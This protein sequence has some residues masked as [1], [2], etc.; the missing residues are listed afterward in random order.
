MPA[1]T[2]LGISYPLYGDAISTTQAQFQDMAEDMD[3][4]AQQLVNRLDAAAMRPAC[5]L[6]NFTNQSIVTNT[7][8]TAVWDFADFNNAGMGNIA[9]SNTRIQLIEQGIYIVGAALIFA[10]AAGTYSVHATL[11]ATAGFGGGTTSLRGVSST[12]DTAPDRTHINPV[13]MFYADGVTTADVTVV[14]RHNAAAS[15]TMQD[16]NF[17]AAK[18]SNAAGGF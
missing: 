17:W 14:V 9:V 16:R 6:S 4:L 15:I 1:N 5:K 13:A 12:L 2:P 7:N 11:Q 8:T 3:T 10:A 18:V